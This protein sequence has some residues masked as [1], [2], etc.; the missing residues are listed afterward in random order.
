MVRKAIDGLEV[1]RVIKDRIEWEIVPGLRQVDNGSAME[2]LFM[3][4]VGQPVPGTSDR[5]MPFCA[6]ADDT[7]VQV[8]QA[9]HMLYASVQAE[10][11]ALAGIPA[12]EGRKSAGGLFVS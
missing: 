4:G 7:E 8:T 12:D 9:V 10:L 3:I 5:I 6:V 11:D 2:L 1:P